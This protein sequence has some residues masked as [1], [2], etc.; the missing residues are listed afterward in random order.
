MAV[1]FEALTEAQKQTLVNMA[2][3]LEIS[4]ERLYA[5]A[6]ARRTERSEKI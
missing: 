4:P 6:M 3:S 5:E 1:P 2:H